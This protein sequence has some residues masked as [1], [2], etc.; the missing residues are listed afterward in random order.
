MKKFTLFLVGLLVSTAMLAQSP[1]PEPDT[2]KVP[3]KQTDPEIKV[4]PRD[5]NYVKEDNVRIMPSEVPAAIKQTLESSPE[6]SGWE[7]ATIYKSKNGNKF[8]IEVTRAD[9]TRI[10]RFDK[11]GKPLIE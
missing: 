2:L 7:K 6:Y 11:S 1:A 9:T 5:A 10:Y 8:T 3:V 4:Q